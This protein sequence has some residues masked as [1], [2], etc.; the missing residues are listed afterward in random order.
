[1]V[2]F[3]TTSLIANLGSLLFN[4]ADVLSIIL[5]VLLSVAFMTIIERKQLAAH[6]RRV[7]PVKWFGKSILWVKLPNSGDTLK[8]IVPNYIRKA[9]S[10]WSKYSCKVI[11]YSM[12]EN[13]MGNRGSKSDLKYKSVK[14]QRVDGSY[15]GFITRLRCTLMGGESR[16]QVKIPSKQLNRG[17]KY[18][19][20]NSDFKST[21]GRTP[22]DPYFVSGFSDAEASSFA[23]AKWKANVIILISKEP[24][25]VT[26]WTVKPRFSIGLHKKDREILDLIKSYFGGVGTISPQSKDSVQYRVASLKDLNGIIIPHFYQYPLLHLRNEKQMLITQKKSRLYFI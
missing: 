6:Q 17:N 24:K 3:V 7:G 21:Y 4:L 23:F 11:S 18:Y 5:P 14:E 1:M 12:S 9:I 10:G 20:S 8:T 22:L 19:S 13:K 16:Y 2:T 26:Q 25:N 15:F